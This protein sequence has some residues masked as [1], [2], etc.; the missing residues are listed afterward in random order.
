METEEGSIYSFSKD[1]KSI[2]VN[3]KW[4]RNFT[5]LKDFIKKGVDYK[6]T[7]TTKKVD[8]KEFHNIKSIVEI[9]K[10]ELKPIQN[11]VKAPFIIT[12]ETNKDV[13]QEIEECKLDLSQTDKNCILICAKD[14]YIYNK[15]FLSLDKCVEE[16][17]RLRLKL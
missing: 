14:Y 4:F 12:R 6:I 13:S 15:G 7:Y 16:F 1:R 17:R 11:N 8:D 9:K 3:G 10:S 2:N 5:P